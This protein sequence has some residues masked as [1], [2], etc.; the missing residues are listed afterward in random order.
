VNGGLL[1]LL[2]HAA[3]ERQLYDTLFLGLLDFDV[4][5]EGLLGAAA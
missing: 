3:A 5:T 2:M 1:Q 4:K